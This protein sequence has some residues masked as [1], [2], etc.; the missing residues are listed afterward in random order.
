VKYEGAYYKNPEDT[1][2]LIN[3]IRKIGLGRGG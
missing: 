3:G 2:R 1:A